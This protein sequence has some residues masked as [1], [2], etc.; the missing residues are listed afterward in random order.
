MAKWIFQEIED[1]KKNIL[2]VGNN[3]D[4][5]FNECRK[6]YHEVLRKKI[7][8]ELYVRYLIYSYDIKVDVY[9]VIVMMRE[10]YP[11]ISEEQVSDWIEKYKEPHHILVY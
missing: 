8:P 6:E 9:M 5:T 10:V 3:I 4:K 2:Y 11:N 7:S 1:I